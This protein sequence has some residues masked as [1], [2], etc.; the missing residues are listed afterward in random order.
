MGGVGVEAIKT[1]ATLASGRQDPRRVNA[2]DR[3]KYALDLRRRGWAYDRI[4]EAM[5]IS[6]ARAHDLVKA[7]YDE[8][9]LDTK[10]A[11]EE[12]RDQEVER[13]DQALE[14]L[15][16]KV[17]K[18]DDKALHSLL[19]LQERRSKL[20]GLD[21]PQK[22]DQTSSDG[23]MSPQPAI[24]ASRLSDQTLQELLEARDQGSEDR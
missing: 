6:R 18:G 5:G 10:R 15:W 20:L 12:V 3:R 22:I 11:A 2:R 21:A 16:P 9:L 4:G 19:R 1:E 13:L 17:E 24:D 7:A 14:A 23:T 8:L